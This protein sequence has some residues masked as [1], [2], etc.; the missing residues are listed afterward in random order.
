[1]FVGSFMR[2]IR[3]SVDGRAGDSGDGREEQAAQVGGLQSGIVQREAE[4][5]LSQLLRDPDP[6]VIGLAPGLDIHVL[7]R[8]N[9]EVAAIHGHVAVQPRQQERILE[10]GPPIVL[11]AFEKN[12]LRVV[13]FREGA[14][15]AGNPHGFCV[16]N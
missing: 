1:M 5:L 3:Q 9:R 6:D 12:F 2:L 11:E 15:C 16:L 4:S 10:F 8:G 7:L 14:R 13:M